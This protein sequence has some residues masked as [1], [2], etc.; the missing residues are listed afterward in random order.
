[1][2]SL[3]SPEQ[4]I[5]ASCAFDSQGNSEKADVSSYRGITYTSIKE[6]AQESAK[7]LFDSIKLRMNFA[8][9]QPTGNELG[10]AR[11]YADMMGLWFLGGSAALPTAVRHKREVSRRGAGFS[12]D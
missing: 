6:C 3:P 1:M 7:Q 10:Y 12:G 9:G 2:H 8:L 5:S 11:Q 4:T